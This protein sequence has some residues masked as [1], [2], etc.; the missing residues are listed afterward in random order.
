MSHECGVCGM[1]CDCD[2]EDMHNPQPPDCEHLRRDCTE[3]YEEFDDDRCYRCGGTGTVDRR[4][5]DDPN[6]DIEVNC[7]MCGGSGD[8]VA[9]SGPP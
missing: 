8:M 1:Y 6:E 7:P 4:T 3:E 2:G 5:S 9:P